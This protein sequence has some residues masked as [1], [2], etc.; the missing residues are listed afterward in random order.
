LLRSSAKLLSV[1]SILIFSILCGTGC[2]DDEKCETAD[3]PCGGEFTACCTSDNCH[4]L[5]DDG[6][7]FNCDGTDCNEAAQEL[8]AHMCPGL[9]L[10][11]PEAFEAV[12]DEILREAEEQKVQKFFRHK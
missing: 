4:Y 10:S 6:Q 3:H 5:A 11:D 12:V 9:S 2:S 1:G 7:R 8:A